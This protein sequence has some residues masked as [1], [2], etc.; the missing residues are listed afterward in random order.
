MMPFFTPMIIREGE[1]CIYLCEDFAFSRR[2]RDAGLDIWVDMRMRLY[3]IGSY[4]F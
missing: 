4:E 1:N 2:V 3:H